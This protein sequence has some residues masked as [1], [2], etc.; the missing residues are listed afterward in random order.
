MFGS[1]RREEIIGT[2]PTHGKRRNIKTM[3]V[4][5]WKTWKKK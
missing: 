1:K 4:F 2:S 3:K 5:S